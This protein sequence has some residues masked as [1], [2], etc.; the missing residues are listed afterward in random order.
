M[1][2]SMQSCQLSLILQETPWKLT[3]LGTQIDR[4]QAVMETW[5]V[6]EFEWPI[7]RSGEVME[8]LKMS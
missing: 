4:V 7:S 8:T 2:R 5:K 6:M 1:Q 3:T